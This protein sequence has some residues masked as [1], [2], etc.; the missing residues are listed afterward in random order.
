MAHKSD[1]AKFV[2]GEPIKCVVKLRVNTSYQK[3]DIR[4]NDRIVQVVDSQNK[5]LGEYE[6]NDVYDSTFST[7]NIVEMSLHPHIMLWS[8]GWNVSF[9][10]NGSTGSGKS[11]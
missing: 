3:Q 5:L 6:A 8:R 10:A 9:L 2:V 4:I 1:I 11:Y 7:R